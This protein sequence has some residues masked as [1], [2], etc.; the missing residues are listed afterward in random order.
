MSLWQDRP[1]SNDRLKVLFEEG[2]SFSQIATQLSKE[3]GTL[4]SRNSA[5]GRANRIGLRFDVP[6]KLPEQVILQRAAPMRTYRPSLLPPIQRKSP[7]KTK[8]VETPDASHAKPF[9]AL[10]WGQ[11]KWPLSLAMEDTTAL[12]LFCAAPT[13]S[14]G[15]APYCAFHR[16]ASCIPTESASRLARSVRRYA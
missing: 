11:C 9:Q 10:G 14:D 16:K 12:S 6:R 5:I 3:F 7:Y 4:I 15:L 1:E 13:D 8:T 2:R